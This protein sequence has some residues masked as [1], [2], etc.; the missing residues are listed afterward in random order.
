MK[1]I[2]STNCKQ[3][4]FEIKPPLGKVFHC[5]D[6]NDYCASCFVEN[7]MYEK[8][9]KKPPTEVICLSCLATQ[10]TH[11][12]INRGNSCFSCEN[13]IDPFNLSDIEA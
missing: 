7:S 6:G 13:T 9:D 3:C 4:D 2:K 8:K 5:A 10:S 11:G 12:V 1:S